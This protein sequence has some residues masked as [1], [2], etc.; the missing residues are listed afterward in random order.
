METNIEAAENEQFR[1]T[2]AA[3]TA[4]QIAVLRAF[5]QEP[6]LEREWS[7][8]VHQ[9]LLERCP[10]LGRPIDQVVRE[11]EDAGLV[12]GISHNL[13]AMRSARGAEDLR[14][15][16]TVDGRRVAAATMPRSTSS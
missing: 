16:M 3:L 15:H 12:A 13:G 8:T 10:R 5:L 9:V 14:H 6:N 4:D 11:L 2:L 1:A 7:G